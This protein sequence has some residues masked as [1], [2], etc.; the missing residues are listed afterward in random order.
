MPQKILLIEDNAA[1]RKTVAR[2]LA[3]NGYEVGEAAT[4]KDGLARAERR[5]PDLII[6]DL[7]L[8]GI[9][10]TEVCVRLKQSP[11]T[12]AVPI[13]ILTGNDQDGQDISCLDVGADDYL[14]KPVKSERLL[15]HC[16]ALL[17]RA[18]PE[19]KR[20]VLALGALRLDY[21]R[22]LVIV[23]GNEN[24]RLTP[25]EFGLLFELAR[26][27]P[28]P[29]DRTELYKLVWG[30]EPPSEGSLKT[31]DVHARRIRLKLGWSAD[32]W[33]SYVHGRGYRLAAPEEPS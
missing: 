14:T 15:A 17:R 25:K 12:A 30:M 29:I 10:G 20:D 21:K 3:E 26:R 28:D 24:P 16:R 32:R 33:L 22:K 31:V 2:I 8:P 19:G 11:R 13:L 9:K 18:A 7:I 23:D 27:T 1:F 6:L 5:A 4:G